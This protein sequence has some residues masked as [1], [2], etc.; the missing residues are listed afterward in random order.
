MQYSAQD[1]VYGTDEEEISAVDV[2]IVDCRNNGRCTAKN[3]AE[4]SLHGLAALSFGHF[5]GLACAGFGVCQHRRA[6]R[7]GRGWHV[8][9]ADSNGRSRP[10]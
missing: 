8:K 2:P 6:N 1:A 5:R 9:Q 3:G 4:P 7:C 10:F